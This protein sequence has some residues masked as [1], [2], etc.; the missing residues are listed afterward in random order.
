MTAHG[1]WKITLKTPVGDKEGLLDLSADGTTLSGSLSHAEHFAVISKGK[2]LGNQLEWS[3]Q[4]ATP[5]R[6]TVKFTA[7]VEKD[8]ITGKVKYFLGSASFFGSRA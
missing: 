6:M 7:T 3:A 5:V 1:K 8:R 4:L 2:I